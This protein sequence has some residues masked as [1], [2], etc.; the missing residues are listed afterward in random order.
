MAKRKGGKRGHNKQQRGDWWSRNGR[1]VIRGSATVATGIATR[2][3]P[4][5]IA[6]CADVGETLSTGSSTGSTGS[7]P[8]ASGAGA[9]PRAVPFSAAMPHHRWSSFDKTQD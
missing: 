2:H 5:I 1:Q 9:S 6:G 4:T 3:P 8:G 7:R